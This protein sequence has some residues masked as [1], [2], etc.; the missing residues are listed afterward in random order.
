MGVMRRAE[1]LV[2][3]LFQ[4]FMRTDVGLPERWQSQVRDADAS[5]RAMII[6]DFVA[7]MTD[8]YAI[9]AAERAFGKRVEL[10]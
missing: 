6:G 5:H 10:G 1:A 9:E 8:R 4:H 7:G 3:E 2:D